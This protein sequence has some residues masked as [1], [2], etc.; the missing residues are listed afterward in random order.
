MSN[1]FYIVEGE[2]DWIIM[3]RDLQ[4]WADRIR[5]SD[6]DSKKKAIEICDRNNGVD[7]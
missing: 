7:E 6:P 5:K 4:R 2:L 1:R 3:D